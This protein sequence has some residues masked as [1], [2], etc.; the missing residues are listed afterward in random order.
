MRS[1]RTRRVRHF[2]LRHALKAL[3]GAL[4]LSSIFLLAAPSPAQ[5]KKVYSPYERETIHQ[6][7]EVTGAT[8]DPAPEGKIVEEILTRRLDVIEPRD[9]V[10]DFARDILNWF[11]ATSR[12][13]VVEREILQRVGKPWD[14]NRVDES[15]R[16]LRA[17]RQL[18]FVLVVPVR[19]SRPDRVKLLV[20]TKDIWS[21]RLNSDLRFAGGELEY[22]LLAPSEENLLG[23]HQSVTARFSLEPDVLTFGFGYRFPRNFG[24][25]ASADVS[26][27]VLVNRES[28]VAEG[29][30]GSIAWKMPLRSTRDE[31]AWQGSFG[32]LK[33]VTR[34]FIGVEQAA[35]DATSTEAAEAI[36]VEYVTDELV[37]RYAVTRSFGQRLKDDFTVG[38]EAQ[39]FVFRAP[40]VGG[41]SRQVARD[42]EASLVPVSDSRVYPF[43]SWNGYATDFL[44][45]TDFSTLALQENYRLGHDVYL[46]LAPIFEAV[47]SSRDLFGTY[48]GAAYTAALGDGFARAY[49]EAAIEAEIDPDRIADA[50]VG[51]GGLVVTP[52]F[53]IGRLVLDV[54]A[55]Q[56]F[57]NFLNRR[58]TLG[59]EG[60]LRG[61]P[62]A[63]FLGENLVTANVEYRSRPFEIATLQLGAVAFFDAGNVRDNGEPFD[64]KQSVGAGMRLVIPQID[65]SVLRFDWGFPLTPAP[66]LGITSPFPGN[67]VITFRQAFGVPSVA[68][69]TSSL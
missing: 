29:S 7:L 27:A 26:A 13:F 43:I 11:H 54:Y 32:W 64:V 34:R 19:G 5:T 22:L 47:G 28:G 1:R 46:K 18:S 36:P 37:G 3:A 44:Q 41:A 49:G 42:F 30:T 16:N 62:T 17:I 53:G 31:W 50:T 67:F 14:P 66:E 8:E 23:S 40:V 58:S 21:L 60:R 25:R 2:D 61:Y 20:L 59:G 39:R 45:I 69:P 33:E 4:A 12:P 15:E 48:P 68:V 65:K 38:V 35:F 51:V 55:L 24:T 56:R 10:P 6:A 57:E 63:A 52:R 9:P